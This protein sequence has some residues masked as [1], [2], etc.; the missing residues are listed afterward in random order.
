MDLWLVMSLSFIS[1]CSRRIADVFG[2]R[3]RSLSAEAISLKVC[4]RAFRAHQW[5]KNALIFVPLVT[6]HAYTNQK[7]VLMAT[8]GFVL[9]CLLASATYMINDIVD[10]EADRLHPTKRLRPFASGVLPTAFGLT[11]APILISISLVGALLLSPSFALVLLLYLALALAYSFRVKKVP[12]LDVFVIGILFTLRIVMGTEVIG[13]GYSP[14]LLSFSWAF[15]LS[16]ALAK[17]HIEVMRADHINVADVAGRGYRAADWP[18]TLSF[19]VGSGLI[20]VVIMLLYLINDAAPSGFYGHFKWLYAVPA[21]VMM[22]LMRIWL[23]SH[24]ME[25]EDDP[26]VFALRD[27]ASLLVGLLTVLTFILAL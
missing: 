14:W 10:L 3:T 12:L 1:E 18:L 22:W 20:S 5:A 11:A 6:G 17:R 13:L 21:F 26:V 15:F 9:L 19:G 24:R 7:S 2:H 4:L 27:R 16:L 23:L 25:L 8:A